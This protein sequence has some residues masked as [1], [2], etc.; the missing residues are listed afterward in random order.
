MFAFLRN[1][2]SPLAARQRVVSPTATVDGIFPKDSP[3]RTALSIHILG[4]HFHDFRK[5]GVVDDGFVI[6]TVRLL[7]ALLVDPARCSTDLLRYQ[8]LL[9]L[10]D[11]L[12]GKV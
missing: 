3:S 2:Q 1:L 5:L 9:C 12:K 7:V 11:F 10:N 4:V 8:A 6:R